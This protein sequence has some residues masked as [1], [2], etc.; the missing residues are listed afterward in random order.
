MV[1]KAQEFAADTALPGSEKAETD[2]SGSLKRVATA[3]RGDKL[4]AP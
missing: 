3:R 1:N 2:S 4:G